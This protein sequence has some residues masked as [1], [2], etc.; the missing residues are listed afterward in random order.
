METR[1][2]ELADRNIAGGE[3]RLE[4]QRALIERLRRVGAATTDAEN[5]LG[6]LRD[7]LAGWLRE[8]KL[9]VAEL[10]RPSGR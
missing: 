8:R 2:L 3:A 4:R 7:T 9:I 1:H 6:L 10:E 5:F